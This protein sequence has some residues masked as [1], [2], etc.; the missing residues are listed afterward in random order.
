[1]AKI[2][3]QLDII[4]IVPARGGSKRLPRKNVLPLAG[5]PLIQWTLDAA[6][7]SGVI[8]LIMVTSD[9]V[10]VL[11][12]AEKANVKT[13]RRPDELAGDTATSMDAILHALSFLETEG[14]TAKRIM[15]LQ[16]TSPL[17]R[18]EDIR[19]AV[20]KMES[21]EANGVISVCEA[22]HSPLWCNTLDAK[23][24]MNDFLRPEVVGKRSQDLPINYRINGAIYLA[25]AEKL[26]ANK[27]FLIDPCFSFEMPRE[28]SIDID[29]LF[30]LKF[31]EFIMSEL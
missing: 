17:R 3:A 8:D 31:C 25:V 14:I 30:D 18:A 15:L 16:P 28:R 19:A 27:S 26:I 11:D 21:T 22:D 29:V 13:I 10:E 4:A 12:I 2:E 6:K 20:E 7:A 23:G 1:M 9:D 24:R 5:K